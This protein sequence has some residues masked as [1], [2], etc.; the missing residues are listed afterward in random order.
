MSW[1]S[2]QDGSVPQRFLTYL[3]QPR[4]FF[5]I[6]SILSDTSGF[7]TVLLR[8][9]VADSVES[10]QGATAPPAHDR[11]TVLPLTAWGM[12]SR[13]AAGMSHWPGPSREFPR[14]TFRTS[15]A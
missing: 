5:S 12:T 14:L 15:I 10:V 7:S 2:S 4:A 8:H 11:T 9:G 3:A 1:L 6:S 13:R